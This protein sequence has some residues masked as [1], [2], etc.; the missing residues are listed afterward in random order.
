M[1]GS[2]KKASDGM[3]EV[4]DGFDV[5]L[6]FNPRPTSDINRLWKKALLGYIESM[7]G[8]T[9]GKSLDMDEGEFYEQM[10]NIQRRTKSLDFLDDERRK[11]VNQMWMAAMNRDSA[12][13]ISPSIAHVT[14]KLRLYRKSEKIDPL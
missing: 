4:L 7:S 2:S 12:E 5:L 13:V 11:K 9:A 6:Q 10:N 8:Y 14:V 1:P 3:Q